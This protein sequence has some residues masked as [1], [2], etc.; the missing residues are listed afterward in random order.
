MT[1]PEHTP[2]AALTAADLLAELMRLADET[3]KAPSMLYTTTER[4]TD[5]GL[6]IAFH[7]AD[8][9]AGCDGGTLIIPKGSSLL[10]W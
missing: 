6:E 7:H 9:P 2:A 1:E 4:E 3:L 5:R 8:D 10:P